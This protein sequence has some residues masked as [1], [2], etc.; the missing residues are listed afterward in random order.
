MPLRSAFATF[1]KGDK[2]CLRM[3]W[4]STTALTDKS[5]KWASP[6]RKAPPVSPRRAR[7]HDPHL[8]GSAAASRYGL[9]RYALRPESPDYGDGRSRWHALWT[10]N[11][12][13]RGWL[14]PAG[15]V[16]TADSAQFGYP[17]GQGRRIAEAA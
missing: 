11:P 12:G 5:S 15:G 14:A 3:S 17:G 1:C 8:S 7:V 9:R 4:S 2:R 6:C 13:G 10:V 16:G